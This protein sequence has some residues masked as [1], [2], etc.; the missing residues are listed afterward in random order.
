MNC[1][2]INHKNPTFV[3]LGKCVVHILRQLHVKYYMALVSIIEGIFFSIKLGNHSFPDYVY[4][5]V[6]RVLMSI[7]NS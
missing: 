6:F 7:T 2:L 3:K 4:R 1:G 5:K